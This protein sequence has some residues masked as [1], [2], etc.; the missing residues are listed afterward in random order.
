[1]TVNFT[2]EIISSKYTGADLQPR[3]CCILTR[4]ITIF[5]GQNNLLH[6][7]TYELMNILRNRSI[8]DV[9]LKATVVILSTTLRYRL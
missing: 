4:Y 3:L 7:T 8:A 1:M 9:H 2:I 6:A 5:Q